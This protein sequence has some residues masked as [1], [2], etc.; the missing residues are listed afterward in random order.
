MIKRVYSEEITQLALLY[1]YKATGGEL[2]RIDTIKKY[3][4]VVLENLEKMKSDVMYIYP[5]DYSK[6]MYYNA[7]DN[8]NI[9]YS[10]IKPGTNLEKVE[11]DYDIWLNSDVKKASKS[12]NALAVLGIKYIDKMFIPEDSSNENIDMSSFV[13]K[14]MATKNVDYNPVISANELEEIDISN[15]ELKLTKK[16]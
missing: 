6:L 7:H 5:I 4:N 13:P 11:L 15:D 9:W 1:N 10:I 2:L 12:S 14:M 8:E 3:E 16:K